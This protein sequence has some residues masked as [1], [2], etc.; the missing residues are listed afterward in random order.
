[1]SLEIKTLKVMNKEYLEYLNECGEK[2]LNNERVRF[3]GH[4]VKEK[5]GLFNIFTNK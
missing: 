2:L 1:M 5:K 3:K 4:L